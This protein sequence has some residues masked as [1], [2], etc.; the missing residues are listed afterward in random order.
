MQL[1]LDSLADLPRAARTLLD[2][3]GDLRV[4]VFNGEIG[5]G[6]TTFIQQLCRELGVKE[7][8]TSPTFSIVNEYRIETGNGTSG[9]IFHLDLYR[10]EQTAEAQDI[11]IEE[12]FYSGNYCFVEWPDIALGLLPEQYLSVD[13]E[14]LEGNRRKMVFLKNL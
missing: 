7:P 12:Y 13:Q 2:F 14:I 5:A 11:G 3:A 9:S 1:E 6:K 4:L 10:L 8:V